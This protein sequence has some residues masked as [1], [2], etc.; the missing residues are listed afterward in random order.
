MKLKWWTLVVAIAGV[1]LA[2]NV[3]MS[4][5][6]GPPS[7]SST[8][9]HRPPLGSTYNCLVGASCQIY[10]D[11]GAAVFNCNTDEACVTDARWSGK[12]I[13][14]MT[15]GVG[16]LALASVPLWRRRR[17]RSADPDPMPS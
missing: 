15:V 1:L 7:S 6:Q 3:L 14:R 4:D 8:P 12:D 9:V 2:M 13:S 16:L 10:G 17:V 5:E 11:P